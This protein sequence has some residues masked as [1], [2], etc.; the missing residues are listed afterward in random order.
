[1][2]T[3]NDAQNAYNIFAYFIIKQKTQIEKYL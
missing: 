3:L 2:T 1:M